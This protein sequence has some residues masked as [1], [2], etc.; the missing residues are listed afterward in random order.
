[1]CEASVPHD[2][3]VNFLLNIAV[4]TI[5]NVSYS[6]VNKHFMQQLSWYGVTCM[7][8]TDSLINPILIKTINVS[9]CFQT[10]TSL[11]SSVWDVSTP[12]CCLSVPRCSFPA[13]LKRHTLSPCRC[14]PPLWLWSTDRDTK[15][16]RPTLDHC[17]TW[18]RIKDNCILF[19]QT[20]CTNRSTETSDSHTSTPHLWLW[21][22]TSSL[23]W[24]WFLCLF[25]TAF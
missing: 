8:H 20:M 15:M 19:L 2:W 22:K 4:L 21:V 3:R 23:K 5:K 17:A 16:I 10:Q 14:T 18:W 13:A 6:T 25:L 12:D 1:M 11:S 24:D 7:C 9:F